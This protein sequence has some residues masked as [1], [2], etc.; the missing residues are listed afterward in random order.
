MKI[1]TL[2]TKCCFFFSIMLFF[3]NKNL[4]YPW[5]CL[6]VGSVLVFFLNSWIRSLLIYICIY[7]IWKSL[8]FV[9]RQ[10]N[11]VLSNLVN[12]CIVSWVLYKT[13]LLGFWQV[14][15]NFFVVI[16]S[17]S[18]LSSSCSTCY[19]SIYGSNKSDW[20]LLVFIR[21]LEPT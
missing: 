1:F 20:K 6:S 12:I 16:T 7:W 21:I 5:A 9:A 2:C 13:S 14:Q 3:M 15:S 18:I 17:R 8:I 4:V 10:F 11:I 19:G